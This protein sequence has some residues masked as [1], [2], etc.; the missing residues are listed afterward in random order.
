[1]PVKKNQPPTFFDKEV[2]ARKL[3][4]PD[5]VKSSLIMQAEYTSVRHTCLACIGCN[6]GASFHCIGI[7]LG[8]NPP[9]TAIF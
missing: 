1:M 6:D 4:S 3:L 8:G 2:F 7:W 9:T 5:P